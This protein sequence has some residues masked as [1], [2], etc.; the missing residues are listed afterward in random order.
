MHV[1]DLRLNRCLRLLVR[2]T[3]DAEA[4]IGVITIFP[5]Y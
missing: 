5:G 4:F 1:D 3:E 2:V